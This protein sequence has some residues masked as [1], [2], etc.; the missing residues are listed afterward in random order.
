M[1]NCLC[2]CGQEAKNKF[3]LG[4]NARIKEYSGIG[5]FN[6]GY[7]AWNKGRKLS[8]EIKHNLSIAHLGLKQSPETIEKIKNTL[9]NKRRTSKYRESHSIKMKE[10]F[11]DHPEVVEK[12]RKAN[13]TNRDNSDI[14]KKIG[15]AIKKAYDE[16]RLVSWNK[17]KTKDT[18]N[19]IMQQA[20]KIKKKFEDPEY[21]KMCLGFNKRGINK[22]EEKLLNILNNLNLSFEYVGNFQFF[23]GNKCPDFIDKEGKKIIE[24]NGEYWHKEND[25][26]RIN[27]F[28]KYGYNTL[29]IWGK[30]LKDLEY[31]KNKILTFS[32]EV[33]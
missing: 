27:L 10:F 1:N 24:L 33:N 12:I 32:N 18:D 23:V 11:A 26:N 21:I 6:R 29:I 5:Q 22:Q 31:L 8:E 30:E 25:L 13:K 4:H 2:G 3:V 19:R 17:G 15:N 7:S 28:R 9:I 14:Q 20:I 16:G